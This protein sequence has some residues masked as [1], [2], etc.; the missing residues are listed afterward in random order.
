MM[1]RV[2]TALTPGGTSSV[3]IDGPPEPPIA[4]PGAPGLSFVNLWA[5]RPSPG[6][7]VDDSDA[8]QGMPVLPEAG[9]TCFRLIRIEPGHGMDM[10]A[11]DTIDYFVLLSGSITLTLDDGAEL[12]LGPGDCLVQA[13][14]RHAWQNRGNH[15]CLLAA[16]I[17]GAVRS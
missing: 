17:V 8:A 4:P 6:L 5:T 2:V 3:M 15:P 10:H 11:T 16:V 1:R 12:D 9:G 7:P 14:A 13:G